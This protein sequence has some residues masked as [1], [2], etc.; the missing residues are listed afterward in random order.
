VSTCK[1]DKNKTNRWLFSLYVGFYSGLIWGVLKLFEYY[2][3]FTSVVPG[4]L[5]EPFYKHSYLTQWQ[6]IAIGYMSFIVLSIIASLIYAAFFYR[7]KGGW[8]GGLYGIAWW[9]LLF[10]LIGPLTGMLQPIQQY[11]RDTIV[12]EICLFLLWG[13]FI[14]YSIALEF[15]EDRASDTQQRT[16]K[17]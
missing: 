12:T 17:T 16:S 13:I 4:F 9:C 3:K 14:G 15:T 8:L 11:S 6:G 7:V 10:L 1:S 2:F 5:L